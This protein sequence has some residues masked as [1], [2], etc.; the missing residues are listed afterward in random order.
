M[1]ERIVLVSPSGQALA[2][3]AK[4][5]ADIAA[6]GAASADA[7]VV[8][9]GW[10]VSSA[11]G[12]V[13]AISLRPNAP[14]GDSMSR[15][16]HRTL[17]KSYWGLNLIRLSPWDSGRVF[18][19]GVKRSRAAMDVL[20]GGDVLIAL[21]RDGLLAVWKAARSSTRRPIAVTGMAAA[22]DRLAH[23]DR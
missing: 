19:R 18:W 7:E 10:D 8:L 2:N 14:A 4:L 20:A 23:P 22:L 21:E 17:R 6:A 5:R 11:P 1:P 3:L 9:L 12:E 15:L 16:L 13:T